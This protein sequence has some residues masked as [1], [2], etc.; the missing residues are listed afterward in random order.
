MV[1]AADSSL[2]AGHAQ[3][4]SFF[5]DGILLPWHVRSLNVSTFHPFQVDPKP[6]SYGTRW[7]L[8]VQREFPWR[9]LIEVSWG[10]GLTNHL[11]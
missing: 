7:S 10:I 4:Q 5:P 8:N 11:E 3:K 9:M 1:P 2:T 6:H